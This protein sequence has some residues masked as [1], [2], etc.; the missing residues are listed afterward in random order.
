[1]VNRKDEYK[2]AFSYIARP[3]IVDAELINRLHQLFTEH[4]VEFIRCSYDDLVLSDNDRLLYIDPPY[5]ETFDKYTSGGFDQEVF[6]KY[7]ELM[8]NRNGC[9]V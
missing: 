1:M 7:L 6:V 2:G 3:K 8:T 9:P 5:L 4:D